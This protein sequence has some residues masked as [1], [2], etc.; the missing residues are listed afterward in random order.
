MQDFELG[1]IASIGAKAIRLD[2]WEAAKADVTI[3]KALAHGLEPEL[4]LGATMTYA[5]RDTVTDFGTRCKNA[6]TKYHGKIRYYETINEPNSNGWPAA[7]FVA[8]QKA[9]YQ[10]IKAVDSRN[11]VYLSGL[12][13]AT[14]G[15]QVVQWMQAAYAA[16]LKGS[17]D[18]LNVHLY[19]D[20]AKQGTWSLW[21]KTFGC[22]GLVSPSI[23]DVMK[24][25]GDGGKPVVSTESGD[26]A[27]SVGETA[28][29][30]AVTGALHDT[31][32]Q[33][34]YIYDML[35]TV[36]GFGMLVP[37]SAGT[38]VDPAGGRWRKRPAYTAYVNNA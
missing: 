15:T 35:N 8:Y 28:Q 22:N 5:G 3:A 33:Q 2:Y 26:N 38:V 27:G 17:Y 1:Q 9:C 25:Y 31:R 23:V 30:T 24:Q 29:A 14:S 18:V 7:D 16:G 6:A 12:N 34:V 19:G 11:V 10:A 36:T 32:L 20:P 21:C 13:P 37:D 4:V